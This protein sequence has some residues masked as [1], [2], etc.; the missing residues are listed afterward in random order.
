MT[1]F[2]D[3]IKQ[4]VSIDNE[5]KNIN[6]KAKILRDQKNNLSQSITNYAT[7]HKLLTSV[8]QISDG[9]LKFGNN[10]LQEPLT[11]KYLEKCLFDLY[12]DNEKVNSIL[13][14]IKQNRESK[15]ISEI[16]RFNN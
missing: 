2:E 14:Y 4:W 15:N 11:F 6:Q 7:N 8:I 9:K 12:Q 16:K 1:S 3:N 13:N 5:L 10:K